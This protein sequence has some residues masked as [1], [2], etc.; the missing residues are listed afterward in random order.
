MRSN[1]NISVSDLHVNTI[2]DIECLYGKVEWK[3][4]FNPPKKN[5]RRGEVDLNKVRSAW[6]TFIFEGLPCEDLKMVKKLIENSPVVLRY[7]NDHNVIKIPGFRVRVN[8]DTTGRDFKKVS[9]K[10]FTLV[11][12]CY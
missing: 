8:H 6:I 3:C 11:E 7:E 9:R 5:G 10:L 1:Y 12:E 4:D 2:A